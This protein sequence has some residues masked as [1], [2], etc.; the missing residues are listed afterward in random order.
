MAG[1]QSCDSCQGCNG[2]Q[3]CNTNCN[4]TGCNTIQAFCSTGGQRV[5]TFSF[6]QCVSSNETFL[7]KQN[8]NRLITYI[9]SAYSAG[10]QQNGGN[11]GLPTS[12]TNDFMTKDMFNKVSSALG[13]LGS[14][15]DKRQVEV[16]DVIYG[17]YFEALE[18]YA[19]TLK[20][21]TS[22]CNN[23]NT[24]CNVTCNG[25]QKCNGGGCQNNSP[26]SCCSSCNTCQNHTESGENS[27]S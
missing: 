21:K 2:C 14:T 6:D 4:S 8:W 27:G 9:N 23:C 15:T 20:Y 22:Q 16:N 26:S 12:D 5:G 24:G 25:C 1:C 11:S 13:N 10:T 17:I 3:S 7:T 18:N 19:N